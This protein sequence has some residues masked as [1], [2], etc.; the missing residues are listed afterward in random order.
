MQTFKRIA[1][2]FGGIEKV[3]YSVDPRIREQ[4]FIFFN[5]KEW[6]NFQKVEIMHQQME[7]RRQNGAF[8]YR[9]QTGE[10]VFKNIN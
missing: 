6:G 5:M 1:E 9:F 8:Y 4:V 7:E 10:S 2:S 3:K